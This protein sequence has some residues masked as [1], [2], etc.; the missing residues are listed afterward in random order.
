MTALDAQLEY[1]Y[2][3]RTF[4]VKPGL[5]RV[6]RMLAAVGNPQDACAYIHI[7][8]TNGKGSTAAMLAAILQVA[9]LRVGLFTSPHL[10]DF[11]ERMQVN[12]RLIPEADCAEV[13][14]C[15]NAAAEADI[16]ADTDH[17]TFFEIVTVAAALHF[18]QAQCDVV[19]WETGMGGRLD[20]TNA[21]KSIVAS[22][23]TP[24]ALDHMQWL[25]STIEAIAAE[26]AGI[27]RA[28][29]PVFANVPDAAAL[30][31]IHDQCRRLQTTLC[32]VCD[33]A[34]TGLAED[35]V[36]Y[37]YQYIHRGGLLWQV[38]IPDLHIASADI[39]LA[40][41]HQ[42]Q[43]A[44]LACV[45]ANWILRDQPKRLDCILTGLA[46]T[47]WLGRLQ[48]L[49]DSPLTILDCAHNPHGCAAL[50]H[51]LR[52]VQAKDWIVAF[53]ALADK[54]VAQMLGSISSIAGEVWYVQPANPRALTAPEFA[55]MCSSIGVA[56]TRAF[57][58]VPSLVR[59]IRGRHGDMR[60]IVIAGS[61]YLAGEVLA[62]WGGGQRDGR[63]DDPLRSC[64]K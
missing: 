52:D 62:A 38:A 6:R 21:V 32:V 59:H 3:L 7:A 8:G 26:K 31:V 48:T 45:V 19:V 41:R 56:Y 1:L 61:C 11:R 18:Q 39:G 2:R 36:V 16:E 27:I 46:R 47:C 14:A 64:R 42:V 44:A 35:I 49:Q 10:I 5:A 15:A 12:G 25:G 22:V 29:V 58:D 23:I 33:A 30:T 4:G 20:A 9:G 63:M 54:N 34:P 28:G 53:G 60:P 50:V 40:G 17:A 37:R 57:D 13:L 43:N 51:A 24:I 55:N